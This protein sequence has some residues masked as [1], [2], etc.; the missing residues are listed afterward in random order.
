MKKNIFFSCH[1]LLFVIIST[2]A[3]SCSSNQRNEPTILSESKVDKLVSSY[4]KEHQISPVYA[5]FSIGKFRCD[6]KDSRDVYRK[7]EAAGVVTLKI[8][9]TEISKKVKTGTDWWSGIA[10]YANKTQKIYTLITSLTEETQKYIIDKVP[11]KNYT[12]PDMEQPAIGDFP[13]FHIDEVTY[14]A[15]DV[16]EKEETSKV[17]FTKGTEFSLI[18]VRNIRIDQERK[19]CAW[20]ECILQN[21]KVTP[22]YRVLNKSYDN[23]KMLFY[24]R[25]QYFIDK[26]W[27]ITSFSTNEFD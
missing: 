27:S 3:V 24:G 22:A 10:E 14:D 25:L 20:F 7:L 17:V 23:Q 11:S 6:D 18:K 8:D 2:C 16:K 12:D 1:L 4:L 15:N 9:T 13:E 21:G 26:G 5:N 19:D